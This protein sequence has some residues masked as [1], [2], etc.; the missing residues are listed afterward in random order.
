MGDRDFETLEKFFYCFGKFLDPGAKGPRRRETLC[1]VHAK[2]VVLRKRTCFCLLSTFYETL[3]SK[4]L[5]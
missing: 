1:R 2:G 4:N 5:A 3:P